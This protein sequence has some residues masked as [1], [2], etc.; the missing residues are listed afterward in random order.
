MFTYILAKVTLQIPSTSFPI[1]ILYTVYCTQHS[2]HISPQGIISSYHRG[3]PILSAIVAFRFAPVDGVAPVPPPAPAF[4][5]NALSFTPPPPP[6]ADASVFAAAFA[7]AI[8]RS[9]IIYVNARGEG[10]RT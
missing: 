5:E 1:R 7:A 8:S 10:M 9:R 6:P 3:A 2:P 4:D